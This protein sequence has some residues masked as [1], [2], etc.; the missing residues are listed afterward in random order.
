MLVDRRI[1]STNLW[2]VACSGLH[3]SG[4]LHILRWKW[5]DFAEFSASN[6]SPQFRTWR[7]KSDPNWVRLK[8]SFKVT[9]K[10]TRLQVKCN[11]TVKWWN[12]WWSPHGTRASFREQS[13]IYRTPHR[14]N[15]A[16]SFVRQLT[17][18]CPSFFFYSS[19]ASSHHAKVSRFHRFFVILFTQH[20]P[21][22]R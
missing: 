5:A 15:A 11:V 10:R 1:L 9:S 12:P 21:E 16:R 7:L 17:K 6:R 22:R 8:F 14:R 3:G 4:W 2:N 20:P 13:G 18:R 19:I